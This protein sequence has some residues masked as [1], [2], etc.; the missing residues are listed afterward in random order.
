MIRDYL[1]D[2]ANECTRNKNII[3][4]KEVIMKKFSAVQI[5]VLT[6]ILVVTF[7]CFGVAAEKATKEECIAK[8]KE[9]SELIKKIGLEK[10]IEKMSDKKGPFF[11]K[12]TYVFC[13]DDVEARILAHPVE[14]FLGFPMKRYRDANHEQPFVKVLEKAATEGSGWIAYMHLRPGTQKASL[15]KTYFLKVPGEK[16]IVCAGIYE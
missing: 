11:W 10:A 9:A 8:C 6:V 12:N 16:A 14:N 7:V 15:K 1:L 3:L 5:T 4:K 13:I 2:S